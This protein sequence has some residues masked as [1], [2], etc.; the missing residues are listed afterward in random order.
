LHPLPLANPTWRA[1]LRQQDKLK[2]HRKKLEGSAASIFFLL[3][4][5]P[6][7]RLPAQNDV[8]AKFNAEAL[9]SLLTK[10]A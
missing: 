7:E 1:S 2:L 9:R 8:F 10:T 6:T 5:M 3:R 4:R